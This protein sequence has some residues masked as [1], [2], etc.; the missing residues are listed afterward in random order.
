MCIFQILWP[1]LKM[2]FWDWRTLIS[3][4]DGLCRSVV[5]QVW[6]LSFPSDNIRAS[7]PLLSWA[8][9]TKRRILNLWRSPLMSRTEPDRRT[10][11]KHMSFL[12]EKDTFLVFYISHHTLI[13]CVRWVDYFRHWIVFMGCASLYLPSTAT[14]IWSL[15]S[16]EMLYVLRATHCGPE[17]HNKHELIH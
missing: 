9:P 15:V 1:K 10:A 5:C 11:H 13:H 14:N 4:F 16:V 2:S 7:T 3:T 12:T 8:S 17:R 6:M